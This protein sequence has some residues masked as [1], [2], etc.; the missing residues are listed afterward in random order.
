MANIHPFRAYRYAESS[1]PLQDLVTQPYDKI[2]PEMQARYL[3]LNP[4]NLV[5]V[6]LGPEE[7]G[8][9]AENNRYTRAQRFFE[10]WIA[11]GILVQDSE[12]SLYTYSQEFLVPDS[13]ERVVRKGFIGLGDVV[14]YEDKVVH[15]HELT[16]SGPKKDRMQVL[17]ATK[18]HFGQI[19]VLYEDAEHAVESLLESNRTGLVSEVT[20]EYGTIHRLSR[21]VDTE[22]I[23]Q[24]QQAMC[25]KK[26]VIADGHHRYETA[27]Q[28]RL[29]HPELK[30]ADR[31]MMTFVNM[32]SD[33]LRI[34][35]TH[36]VLRNFGPIDGKNFL[37]KAAEEFRVFRVPDPAALTQLFA[38][39]AKELIRIG[40]ML[41]GSPGIYVLEKERR[42]ELDVAVLHDRIFGGLLGISE[43]DVRNEKHI[44]YIRGL[45]NATDLVKSG[46]ADAAFLLEAAT[47]D[48]VA[49]TALSGGVMP[50]KST[51]FYPKLLTGLTIYRIEN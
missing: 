43:E 6:I 30:G 18:A 8:D 22:A 13:D 12:D 50:Q 38:Q 7:T 49:R 24:I 11:E 27:V 15:R 31:V 51:D 1:G 46:D 41:R 5:R 20:D 17:E 44:R 19:F 37:S 9:S 29:N 21:V 35:A 40:V 45:E 34:L 14:P 3:S 23:R 10:Q 48:Q 25:D 39:P 32:H 33:G 47:I 26:L 2:S 36:R 28:F 16:L 4:R 42:D